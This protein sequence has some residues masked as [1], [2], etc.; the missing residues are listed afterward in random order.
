[1]NLDI[2]RCDGG[3]EM[4]RAKFRKVRS[5]SM[6]QVCDKPGLNVS[7][8]VCQLRFDK[9]V[10]FSARQLFIMKLEMKPAK[11]SQGKAR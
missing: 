2:P 7:I 8:M 9:F 6:D 10:L 4:K 5:L 11:P 3:P 1:M